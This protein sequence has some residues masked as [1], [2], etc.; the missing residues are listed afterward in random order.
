MLE[1]PRYSVYDSPVY[2]DLRNKITNPG[3]GRPKAW[4]YPWCVL[5]GRI[6]KH[7]ICMDFGC[8]S[9]TNL[10]HHI[11]EMSDFLTV[12]LD[13]DNLQSDTEKVRFFITPTDRI[14]FPDNFFDRVFSVSVL[15]HVPIAQRDTVLKELFRVLRPGGLAVLVIDWVF[16][17]NPSLLQQLSTSQYLGRIG[18]QIYGNYD[19]AKILDDYSDIVT[20]LE[21]IDR[22]FL[23]GAA[24]FDENRILA[25]TDILVSLSD[26]VT[27]VELFKYTALGLILRKL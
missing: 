17:M 20:P 22:S 16:G 15:E 2:L 18:S 3:P 27:D 10:T 19:F 7:Q 5:N 8:G 13:L 11:S 12:G 23:P 1:W 26:Q 14:E 4:A 21:S 9:W 6:E 25:D 24:E